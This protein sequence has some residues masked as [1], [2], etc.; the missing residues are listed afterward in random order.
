[1]ASAG[2]DYSKMY[3]MQG[4]LGKSSS[5]PST[6]ADMA[7]GSSY[8]HQPFDSK[9]S[10]SYSGYNVPQGGYGF[11]PTAV[12]VGSFKDVGNLS[13]SLPS[14]PSSP[15][16]SLHPHPFSLSPLCSHC[17]FRCHHTYQLMR[18]KHVARRRAMLA[19]NCGPRV[20]TTPLRLTHLTCC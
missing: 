4:S 13:S 9:A 19:A 3:T 15:L 16:S 7:T 11:I 18:D 2:H 20:A 8:K 5:M 10:S 12:C 17:P 14:S 1:M 6:S